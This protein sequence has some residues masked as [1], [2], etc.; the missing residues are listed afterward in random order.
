MTPGY[1]ERTFDP[2]ERPGRLRLIA[3][4]TGQDGSLTIHQDAR[5]YQASLRSGESI[6]HELKPGRHAWVQVLRGGVRVNGDPLKAGDGAALSRAASLTVE[7]DGEGE[8]L[9]FDLA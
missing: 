3:S 8:I 4:Q 1:E 5:L 6:S 7:A 9:L 2:T